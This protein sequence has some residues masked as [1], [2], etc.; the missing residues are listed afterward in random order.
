MLKQVRLN[1][2]QPSSF[3]LCRFAI[4]SYNTDSITIE[5]AIEWLIH[6]W[7]DCNTRQSR[8]D[9]DLHISCT[10]ITQDWIT[11]DKRFVI[12]LDAQRTSHCLAHCNLFKLQPWVWR[13][14]CRS[15]VRHTVRHQPF[16]KDVVLARERTR[17]QVASNAVQ[18]RLSNP[19]CYLNDLL[20]LLHVIR[21]KSTLSQAF[22]CVPVTVRFLEDIKIAMSVIMSTTGSVIELLTRA[23]ICAQHW[24]APSG[25]RL[26]LTAQIMN[27]FRAIKEDITVLILDFLLLVLSVAVRRPLFRSTNNITLIF[28]HRR[29]WFTG[30]ELQWERKLHDAARTFERGLQFFRHSL[31]INRALRAA[32]ERAVLQL[33]HQHNV[34]HFTLMWLISNAQLTSITNIEA[35]YNQGL[36]QVRQCGSVVAIELTEQCLRALRVHSPSQLC[37]SPTTLALSNVIRIINVRLGISRLISDDNLHL[38]HTAVLYRSVH[39]DKVL[40]VLHHVARSTTVEAACRRERRHDNIQAWIIMEC[41]PWL[42]HVICLRFFLGPVWI[43]NQRDNALITVRIRNLIAN[44]KRAQAT[45]MCK[46]WICL[47]ELLR[48]NHCIIKVPTTKRAL[49]YIDRRGHCCSLQDIR[50]GHVLTVRWVERHVTSKMAC[51]Q[52]TASVLS[53]RSDRTVRVDLSIVRQITDQT[54][55]CVR[56][57]RCNRVIITERILGNNSHVLS[58]SQNVRITRS[59]IGWIKIKSPC[60]IIRI[61]CCAIS[62]DVRITN[63][64]T[65]CCNDCMSHLIVHLQLTL[66]LPKVSVKALTGDAAIDAVQVR[67]TTD[68]SFRGHVD[69]VLTDIVLD[70]PAQLFIIA[71][72]SSTF[73]HCLVLARLVR[74]DCCIITRNERVILA[75]SELRC[76]DV[77]IVRLED[78]TDIARAHWQSAATL[79]FRD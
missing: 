16:L 45:V 17:C 69:N 49:R 77:L 6:D 14:D 19:W 12:I 18:L 34:A 54:L 75:S 10:R 7:I 9:L 15:G 33:R 59:I 47:S 25:S 60:R 42:I 27:G 41:L 23:H 32:L 55:R 79:R 57:V 11:P 61:D 13:P 70:C 62:H 73:F 65:L 52:R 51:H 53:A 40:W 66:T 21:A 44:N 4:K 78:L 30:R 74:Q 67:R 26:R 5:V 35:T 71:M 64:L 76:N 24:Q 8:I 22:L 58:T 2:E 28:L 46:G 63:A 43:D 36:A 39:L 37:R 29:D 3:A 72:K 48:H 1:G 31:L 56:R 50:Q 38:T 20:V 68:L